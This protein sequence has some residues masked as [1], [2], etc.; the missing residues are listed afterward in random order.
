MQIP[1]DLQQAIEEA[2]R[3]VDR[4]TLARSVRELTAA[5]KRGDFKASFP[6]AAHRTA[7]LLVRM[8]AT[9]AAN[10]HVF[11]EARR[12]LSEVSV[13]SM[14]DL[15]A[16]P[17]TSMWAASEVFGGLSRITLLE[18]DSNLA[19]MG[20]KL[21]AHHQDEAVRSATWV[22]EDIAAYHPEPHDLVVISYSLGELAAAGAEKLIAAAWQATRKLL[23]II[24][25][26]TPRNFQRVLRARQSL[27]SAGAQLAA[28]CPHHNVCPLGAAGDWCHFAER[29]ERTAEH[30]RLK[31]AELGYEDEKFSYLIGT[32]SA[33]VWPRGRIVRHPLFRPGHVRLALCTADGLREETV[34]KSQKE[35]YRAARKAKWGDPLA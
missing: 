35:Q 24:E 17:G 6:T 33:A 26:G 4:G 11:A 3:E 20:K 2:S 16:G 8:P 23:V 13:E 31:G 1:H 28:P 29:L 21:A 14:L 19:E 30:R 10:C 15:G 5:Y 34:G 9:F 27:I 18:R 22:R 12:A 7:Y 25:P 32:R